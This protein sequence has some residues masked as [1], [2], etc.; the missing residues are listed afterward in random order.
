MTESN[1]P[2]VVGAD[3]SDDSFLAVEWAAAEA[4][5]RR[6]RL[7]VVNA[8]IWPLMGVPYAGSPPE[9]I[10]GHVR[11]EARATV[12]EATA[13]ARAAAPGVEVSGR[14]VDG[15]AQ[16]AL[17]AESS[18]ANLLV[19]GNQGLGAFSS[20]MAG[21]VSVAVAARAACPVVIVR[22]P[23]AGTGSSQ[24]RVVV[25]VDG[26]PAA[27]R[28]LE[29]A[30]DEASRRHVG[31]TAVRGWLAPPSIAPTRTLGLVQQA[32]EIDEIETRLVA[33]MVAVWSEKYPD[34]DVAQKVVHASAAHAMVDESLGAE[35]LVVGS[36]GRGGFT[37]LLLGSVS[38]AAIH[39]AACTVA[40]VRSQTPPA[41]QDTA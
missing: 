38:Q 18:R 16:P 35:L 31:V 21:S 15:P 10:Y 23:H 32:E 30:L 28:A 20:M 27:E 13:R 14:L 1:P 2:V 6:R 9:E 33:E 26:S 37:G 22:P 25:G 5:S 19:V 12:A 34:V 24:G 36:R 4:L 11:D 41:I 8:F 7:R 29:F 3:G 39:R 40:V 17:I